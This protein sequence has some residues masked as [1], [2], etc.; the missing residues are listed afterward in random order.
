MPNKQTGKTPMANFIS[1]L[2]AL[3]VLPRFDLAMRLI[4]IRNQLEAANVELAS[5]KE[6][7]ADN[8]ANIKRKRR[9]LSNTMRIVRSLR[10]TVK[11]R[12]KSWLR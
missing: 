10:Q 4:K 5:A 7:L 8:Q 3:M 9:A 1:E 2:N 6:S 11:R 12:R